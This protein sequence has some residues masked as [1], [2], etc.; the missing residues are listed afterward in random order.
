MCETKFKVGQVVKTRNGR[1]ARVICVD[2]KTD[3]GLSMVALYKSRHSDEENYGS[4]TPQGKFMPDDEEHDCDLMPPMRT[5]WVNL[6]CENDKT[7][8]RWHHEKETADRLGRD[9]KAIAKA[10]PVEI[11]MEVE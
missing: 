10:I 9:Y 4:F 1:E 5:V 6:Y 2:R 7:N 8:A 11:P 3:N